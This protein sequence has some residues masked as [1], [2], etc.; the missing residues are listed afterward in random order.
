LFFSINIALYAEKDPC[1]GVDIKALQV[2]LP[3]SEHEIIYKKPFYD[4]CEIVLKINN[5]YVPIYYNKDYVIAGK[6]FR[7]GEQ[8][9]S[10]TLNV[11][12]EKNFNDNLPLLKK[13]VAIIY[14]PAKQVGKELYMFT[15]P[16]CPHCE[17]ANYEIKKF[18]DKYGITINV[19]MIS[20]HGPKATKKCIEAVCRDFKFEDYIKKDWKQN[21]DTDDFQCQKGK[22]NN[23]LAETVSEKLNV[24]GV[25]V[26]FTGDGK[27][28]SGA[29]IIELKKALGAYKVVGDE[30]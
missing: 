10:R 12:K 16:L 21:Q 11:L 24:D 29:N 27:Y 15:D 5:D 6:L 26:F 30:Y 8:I 17:K 23:A 3:I 13:A 2:H 19:L 28:V 4:L 14:N 9:T 22:D 20:V 25:P 1:E 7:N 18:A